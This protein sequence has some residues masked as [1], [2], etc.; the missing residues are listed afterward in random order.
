MASVID[1]TTKPQPR[2]TPREEDSSCCSRLFVSW[3]T[4]IIFEGRS[5]ILTDRDLGPL[6][7]GDDSETNYQV[8]MEL[9]NKEVIKKGTEKAN[10]F[11]VWVQFVGYF[12]FA[13][14]ILWSILD[15]CC[16]V[17]TPLMSRLIIQHVEK[18]IVLSTTEMIVLT[19]G[20]SL[21]PVSAGFS[22]GQMI[23]LAKRKSLHIYAALTMAVYRK[24]M[25]LS[26]QGRASV[27]TGQVINMLS[28][29]ASNAMEGGVFGVIPLLVAPPVV[30]IVLILLHGV[31]GNSMFAGFGFLLFSLPMNF[32]IFRHIVKYT[33]LMV[34][35]A[36]NRVKLFNELITGIRIVK[37]Y[38][39]EV[40]FKSLIDVAR[41]SE[42]AAI[43]KHAV[44]MQCGMMVVH[45]TLLCYLL[46]CQWCPIALLRET[47]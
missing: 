3:F 15:F 31:I 19:V 17:A 26:A 45:V 6:K 7:T 43:S 1:A 44:W 36:D 10:L 46:R 37:Y 40:P 22:R 27:E 24:T 5:K 16:Q 42:L 34:G 39:W 25:R 28:S 2:T 9:W 29:D 4:P 13:K 38:S 21:A 32:N 35:R 11:S 23:L 30:I 20:L 33:K 47:D 8:L 18:A 41:N 12:T 14:M